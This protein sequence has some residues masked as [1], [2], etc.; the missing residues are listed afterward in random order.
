MAT[1]LTTDPRAAAREAAAALRAEHDVT[2]PAVA[3]ALKALDLAAVGDDEDDDEDR[4]ETLLAKAEE[5]EGRHSVI[6]KADGIDLVARDRVL[7]KM[8]DASR[9]CRLEAAMLMDTT[10]SIRRSELAKAEEA[11][12]R[13]R[14]FAHRAA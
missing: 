3:A 4:A 9:A 10:G 5:L 11:A 13:A 1:T 2:D 8:T 7:R 14:N 6:A 12:V